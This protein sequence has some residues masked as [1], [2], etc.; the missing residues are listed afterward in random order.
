MKK[1]TEL[2]LILVLAL[3]MAGCGKNHTYRAAVT[4]PAGGTD[5]FVF[6]EEEISPV[7]RKITVKVEDDLPKGEIVLK[8]VDV[9]E[10]NAYEPVSISG[11]TP[12]E[13]E[14]EKGG[15]FR[16]GISAANDTEKDQTVYVE[17]RGVEIRIASDSAVAGGDACPAVCIDGITYYDTGK[18]VPVEPDESVIEYVEIPLGGSGAAGS[19]EAFARLEE[20]R[21]IVCLI[22]NEWYEF[23][24]K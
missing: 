1:K 17:V 19:I 5:G 10:E 15:W 14:A 8:T 21:M 24:V 18:A 4:I 2:L 7:G 13:M 23:T 16:I 3:I 9:R 11:G 22:N 20:G 12:V 6:S